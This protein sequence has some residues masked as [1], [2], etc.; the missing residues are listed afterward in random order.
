MSNPTDIVIG[1]DGGASTTRVIVSDL[2]GNVLGHG[3]GG[4]C[5]S[6]QYAN[7]AKNVQQA[8]EKALVMADRRARDVKSLTAG[9][10]GYDRIS[11]IVWVKTL[12]ALAGIACPC[13]HV[14]DALVAH[15]G[16]FVSEL[17]IVI[18]AGSGCI[19]FGITP[20]GQ[21][22]RNYDFLHYA[23]A[24]SKLLGLY[25]MQEALA[26]N[27]DDSD[28]NLLRQILVHWRV[29]TLEKIREMGASGFM[30][31][32]PELDTTLRTLAPAITAAASKGSHLA[33][34]V[35]NQAIS[36]TVLGVKIMS[37]LMPQPL[38]TALVG[39]V[40]NSDY[41][42]KHLSQALRDANCPVVEPRLPPTAGAVLLALKKLEVQ[43]DDEV[44]DNL[45]KSSG[46]K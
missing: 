30:A 20:A 12:T 37:P 16:A 40:A 3:M 38:S 17:G 14:N 23:P 44:I 35:C 24:G 2:H 43:I 32:L 15:S 22:I 33:Q 4:S 46:E 21:H 13:Q 41:F 26:G 18:I 8:I 25:A 36:I 39:S 27:I 5:F 42:K 19:L 10:A 7:A 28:Q 34:R 11:D 1:I 31:Q 6:P 9:I 29:P 45:R